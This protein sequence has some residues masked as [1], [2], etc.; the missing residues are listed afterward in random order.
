[1]TNVSAVR[2]NHGAERSSASQLWEVPLDGGVPTALTAAN[3]GQEDEPG[4]GGDIGESVAWQLPSGT[5]LQSMGACGTMFLS[6]LT[7]DMHTTRVNVPGVSDSS[8]VAGVTGDKLV[9]LA[10]VR[11]A[12]VPRRC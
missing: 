3:S 1:M 6:R 2:A 10:Q 11:G 12:A 9:L 5:F 4:F 7:P 8:G